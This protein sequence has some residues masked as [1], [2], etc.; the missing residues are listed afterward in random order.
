MPSIEVVKAFLV[1]QDIQVLEFVEP[2]PTAETAAR[3]VGCSAAEI[4]KTI[5][6]LIGGAP[7]VVV[8]SGDVRVK[9]PKLKEATGLTGKVRLPQAEEVLT[10]T[11]YLPGGVCPFLLP[12]NLPVLLDRSM[13]RFACVYAA[14]GN[15]HSAVPVTVDQ[16]LAITGG[17]EADVCGPPQP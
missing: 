8:T 13:R 10:Y 4:A 11:G 3:A 9:N 2:T 17:K 14:A 6:F 1:E 16:L 5:L 12:A 15:A 7:I